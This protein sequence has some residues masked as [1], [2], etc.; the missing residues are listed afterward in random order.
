MMST[1]A[2]VLI[3]FIAWTAAFAVLAPV[4]FFVVVLLAGPHSSILP[5]AMQPAVWVLGWLVL[6]GLPVVAARRAWVRT[7]RPY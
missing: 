2:R 6:L 4:C 3:A 7:G 5:S 1:F